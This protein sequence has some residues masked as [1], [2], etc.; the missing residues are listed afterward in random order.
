MRGEGGDE[1]DEVGLQLSRSPLF[2]SC[3]K[4]R[5]FCALVVRVHFFGNRPSLPINL[6]NDRSHP[7]RTRVRHS[8]PKVTW[9]FGENG[10]PTFRWFFQVDKERSQPPAYVVCSVV[11][12]F[13]VSPC[14]LV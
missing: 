9:K 14:A 11:H 8:L 10:S 3:G 6:R 2:L 7:L 5:L 1:V 12:E 13:N 4:N